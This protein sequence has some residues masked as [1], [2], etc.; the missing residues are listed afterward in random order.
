MDS[1][2]FKHYQTQ[3]LKQT[4]QFNEIDI[5]KEEGHLARFA[6]FSANLAIFFPSIPTN[7]HETL[8]KK[9]LLN[10][11]FETFDRNIA[12]IADISLFEGQTQA[13]FNIS[14]PYIFC[15]FHL[16]SYRVFLTALIRA[17]R[18]LAILVRQ[19]VFEE[20]L[21]EILKVKNQLLSQYNVNSDVRVINADEPTAALKILRLLRSDF[22][23]V[24]YMDAN[25]GIG[26]DKGEKISFLNHSLYVRKGV[27]YLSFATNVPI[28]PIVSYKNSELQN[29]VH[30]GNPVFP[31]KEL[32]REAFENHT[33]QQLYDWFS[34]FVVRFPEQWEVW[35][36]INN[37]M[38][39]V[40]TPPLVSNI[41]AF[42]KTSYLFNQQRYALF[43]L[44]SSPVVFD[45][46]TFNVME[47]TPYLFEYLSQ[48]TFNNP[49][50]ILGTD[51]FQELVKHQVI[52]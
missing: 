27:P 38:L 51:I 47:I 43:E 19:G 16:G 28:L 26:E 40:E 52:I 5:T 24:A 3:L 21:Q 4:E 41:T 36:Y 42:Q 45:R 10:V 30:I 44:E 49:E 46:L 15:S 1:A 7:L 22:S 6:F 18:N 48:L 17:G 14:Q 32:S 12:H 37:F 23:L 2:A 35:G 31:D 25:S 33:I 29:I 39:P 13:F 20:Q 11:S 9:M 34:E 50:P 8:Y